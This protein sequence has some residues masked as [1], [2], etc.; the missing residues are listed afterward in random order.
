MITD[1][2]NEIDRLVNKDTVSSSS[3]Q[4]EPKHSTNHK[5]KG[6]AKIFKEL[7]N[8]KE[9]S[10]EK[11]PADELMYMKDTPDTFTDA[12][13]PDDSSRTFVDGAQAES[14]SQ[15]DSPVTDQQPQNFIATPQYEESE[16]TP[17]VEKFHSRATKNS[18]Q[19]Q[20]NHQVVEQA[21]NEEPHQ[22]IIESNP[23]QEVQ[24]QLENKVPQQDIEEKQLLQHISN[25]AD[26]SSN[27][28]KT[29][30]NTI[31]TSDQ[32]EHLIQAADLKNFQQEELKGDMAR[33]REATQTGLRNMFNNAVQKQQNFI[34][35]VEGI[36]NEQSAVPMTREPVEAGEPNTLVAMPDPSQ[37]DS[38]DAEDTTPDNMAGDPQ[39]MF[40]SPNKWQQNIEGDSEPFNV[41]KDFIPETGVPEPA[42]RKSKI[43]ELVRPSS[44][45]DSND[46]DDDDE[47]DNDLDDNEGGPTGMLMAVPVSVP[48]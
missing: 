48:S 15:E 1:I 25:T 7:V 11:P 5:R 44:D 9:D 13:E 33:V 23:K 8:G 41:I 43:M 4:D 37:D 3:S 28:G 31:A 45:N 17:K 39:S 10:D 21:T 14:F 19:E 24:V 29:I 42:S 46:D 38:E 20:R 32:N 35:N 12:Q 30:E 6:K 34:N 22:E 36:P 40:G 18:M 47:D 26:A 27:T 2:E 16:Q